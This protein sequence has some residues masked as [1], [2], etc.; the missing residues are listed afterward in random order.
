MRQAIKEKQDSVFGIRY[1]KDGDMV[2][3]KMKTTAP[4]AEYKAR[5][6]IKDSTHPVELWHYPDYGPSRK[7][8]NIVK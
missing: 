5:S 4:L 2:M 3:F 1:F 6:I 8:C 7:L